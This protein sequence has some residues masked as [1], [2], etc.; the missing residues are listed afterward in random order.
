MRLDPRAGQALALIRSNLFPVLAALAMV[1]ALTALLLSLVHLVN[2]GRH[3][4]F[5]L[6]P[7]VIVA[8]RWG[9]IPALAASVASVAA[10]PFFFY[11]PRFSFYVAEFDDLM[12]LIVFAG[13]SLLTSHLAGS[14][15]RQAAEL[16][17]RERETRDLYALSRTL[18]A[19]HSQ[20]EIYAAV[21]SHLAAAVQCNVLLWRESDD[22]D[23]GHPLGVGHVSE[24]LRQRVAAMRLGEAAAGDE[25]VTDP[26]TGALWLLRAISPKK[27]KLGV[28]A[29]ELGK[30]PRSAVEDIRRHIDASLAEVE[31]TL[32]NLDIGR[33][34]HEA[35]LRAETDRLRDAL[36]GSVSHDL[37]S[38]LTS[39]LCSA[40]VLRDVPSIAA[41]RRLAGLVDAIQAEAE[42]HNYDIQTLLD[43]SRISSR[44]VRPERQWCDPTDIVNA[45][46][47]RFRARYAGRELKLRLQDNLPL[48][49]VD[50][51]LVEQAL[52]QAL[53]NAAKYS[54][55]Q[56]LIE[57]ATDTEAGTVRLIVR[58][59]GAGLT[60][61]EKL[62]MWTQF[63]RGHRHMATSTGS[64]LGLWVAH[65][66]VTA[67]GGRSEAHSDGEG[68]GS[69]ITMA[70][71]V[72]LSSSEGLKQVDPALD[73]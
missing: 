44:G 14:L 67:N 53:D 13:L 27:A 51:M 71:P 58:D 38:P 10:L 65:A 47:E 41:D 64:G 5:Y 6:L 9:T 68:R 50:S 72:A 2:L 56:S 12:T 73:E 70:F 43:A 49:F 26:A 37:R 7:I 59:Q 61:A 28:I 66:F 45:A 1:V 42:R 16:A 54:P 22:E 35:A 17:R 8:S 55:P 20:S 29:V 4:I 24:V 39:I 48:L 46:V 30:A 69:T 62:G 3:T 32:D 21:Q 63:F 33:A 25:V 52:L 31:T 15:K 11:P 18:A 23:R 19:A 36:I 60:E 57:I 40:S 34:L